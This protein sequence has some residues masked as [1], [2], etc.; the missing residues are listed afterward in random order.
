MAAALLVL[1]IVDTFMTGLLLGRYA[2]AR[3][4]VRE[5]QDGLSELSS[6]CQV[7]DHDLDVLSR[8]VRDSGRATD[9]E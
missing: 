2:S 7:L 5:V 1:V 8:I 9:G 4:S 6:Q 3:A